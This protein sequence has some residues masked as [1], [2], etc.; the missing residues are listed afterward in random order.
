[1]SI[2]SF[3]NFLS[4]SLLFLVFGTTGGKKDSTPSAR[5]ARERPN[6]RALKT[7]AARGAF[8]LRNAAQRCVCSEPANPARACVPCVPSAGAPAR[9]AFAFF[10][11]RKYKMRRSLAMPGPRVP[12]LNPAHALLPPLSASSFPSRLA[13]AVP[14]GHEL[15]G[16]QG[17]G[18]PDNL[19]YVTRMA[20]PKTKDLDGKRAARA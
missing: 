1:M 8:R 5:P 17:A 20:D 4:R 3:F 15:Q 16:L 9:V 12:A 13:A 10:C 18:V 14:D 19:L 7:G 6:V 2:N 11:L